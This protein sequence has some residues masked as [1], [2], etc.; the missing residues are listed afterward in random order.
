MLLSRRACAFSAIATLTTTVVVGCTLITSADDLKTGPPSIGKDDAGHPIGNPIDNNNDGGDRGSNEAG[1]D[2]AGSIPVVDAATDGGG[3][4]TTSFTDDFN[5]AN[6]PPGNGWSE[7]TP[8]RLTI[9]GG[10]LTPKGGDFRDGFIYRANDDIADIEVGVELTFSLPPEGDP[11][12]LA[13]LQRA[14]VTQAG[15]FDGYLCWVGSAGTAI[16]VGREDGASLSMLAQTNFPSPLATGSV[17]RLRC[18]VTGQSPVQILGIVEQQ[19][20][21]TWTEISRASFADS[22]P[23]RIT[24]SG[25][26]G[27]GNNTGPVFTFDNFSR[28][29]L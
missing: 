11:Q 23:Q 25:T 3:G 20:G 19:T 5:R 4:G 29:A 21:A 8:G 10:Y 22:S 24:K 18:R 6:G 2:D 28:T 7:K 13:R 14:T 17:H 1:R 9:S 27:L 15:S 12:V 16:K 26:V